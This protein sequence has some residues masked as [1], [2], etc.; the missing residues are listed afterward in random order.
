[1][2]DVDIEEPT[3]FL[4]HL[5]LGCTQRGCK[6]N[7]K[8]FG[9][10][11]KMSEYRISAGATEK[12]PGWDKPRAKTS[13]CPTTWKDMLEKSWNGIANWQTRKQSICTKFQVVAWM[14]ITSRKKLE[15]ARFPVLVWTITKF[16]RKSW[17]TEVKCMK[18]APTLYLNACTW[19]ELTD[20]TFCGQSTNL[21]DLSRNGF[22]HV[23]DDWHD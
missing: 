14:I 21:H 5:Y 12:L 16:K 18:F 19:H 11:N 9:Q 6:P 22:K 17:K 15:S 2:K 4:D 7:E 23:T 3:S 20:L 13:A 8:I 1:M 10:Y